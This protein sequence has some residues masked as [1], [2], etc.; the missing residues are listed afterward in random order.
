MGRKRVNPD[1]V[2]VKC[3][4]LFWP[5][6]K[7]RKYCSRKCYLAVTDGRRVLAGYPTIYRP[8]HPNAWDNGYIFE[9]RIVME[10]AIGRMLEDHETVHHING[11]KTD[12]RLENLQLRS[13][14]HGKGVVLTCNIC[15]SHDIE[16]SALPEEALTAAGG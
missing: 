5:V 15:G 1:I 16:A 14:R 6:K 9:H 13:G 7:D 4:T 11:I 2:C 12:N 10:E 3:G 8:E